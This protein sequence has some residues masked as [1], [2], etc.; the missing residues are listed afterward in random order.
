MNAFERL[1]DI[2]VRRGLAAS[3]ERAVE[4]VRAGR[5]A[6]RE[7]DHTRK[8]SLLRLMVV[9]DSEERW[10]FNEPIVIVGATSK[11]KSGKRARISRCEFARR[12]ASTLALT[13][14]DMRF[15]KSLRISVD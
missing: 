4:M 15:L 10:R 11:L 3:S 12:A 6:I 5:V 8:P 1:I 14:Q 9:R 13:P 2:L 7:W